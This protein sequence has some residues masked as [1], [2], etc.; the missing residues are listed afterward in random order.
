MRTQL[1]KDQRIDVEKPTASTK[2][3]SWSQSGPIWLLGAFAILLFR[4]APFYW[5][6]LLTAF[7]GYA[8]NHLWKKRSFYLF[9]VALAIVSMGMVRSGIDPFWTLL[10]S[11]SV[12]FSWLL[13]FL[14]RQETEVFILNREEKIHALEK[15][16]R[17]LEKQLRDAKE[18]LSEGHKVSLVDPQEKMQ[19]EQAQR[20]YALLREQF[21]EKSEILDQTRK[22]LFHVENELLALQKACA[23]KVYEIPEEDFF[24]IKDLQM[25]EDERRDLEA[26]VTNLQDFI[27][28]LLGPKQRISRH[29]K[30]PTLQE[31]R[32]Q[33][34]L[35]IQERID[36]TSKFHGRLL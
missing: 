29:R 34:P 6:L 3:S 36:Q 27:S 13:I 19:L 25:L 23:E 15:S 21:D 17:S 11:T 31:D 1:F 35:L 33:L 2:P 30:A 8:T 18:S 4:L 24:L 22:E 14:G 12:A 5:P 32:E 28:V 9:L 26:Q 16:C 10:L 20:Q 7:V